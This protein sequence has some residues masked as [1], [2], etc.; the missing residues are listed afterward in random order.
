MLKQQEREISYLPNIQTPAGLGLVENVEGHVG[1]FLTGK[2]GSIPQQKSK[3]RQN[4]NIA[5]GARR[6]TQKRR[7]RRTRKQA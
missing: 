4:M 3:I 7:Q 6:L 5:G 2:T 1:S